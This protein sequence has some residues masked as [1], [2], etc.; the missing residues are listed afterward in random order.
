MAIVKN[1]TSAVTEPLPTT[2]ELHI[3]GSFNGVEFD[4]VGRGEGNPKDGSQNLHLK[5]TK[6][7]LQFSPWMLVP[8]IGYGFYQYLP[9]PDGEMSPYQAAMYGGSGAQYDG[10]HEAESKRS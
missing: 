6:G 7:A 8:H 4:L 1:N 10:N 5:S 2:H 9:Y 3:F